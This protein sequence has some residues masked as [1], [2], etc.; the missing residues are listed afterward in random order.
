MRGVTQTHYHA[1]TNRRACHPVTCF[2]RPLNR[3]VAAAFLVRHN[4]QHWLAS[5]F[6]LSRERAR[7]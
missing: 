6:E 4:V 7:L 3:P 1:E 5:A 2:A